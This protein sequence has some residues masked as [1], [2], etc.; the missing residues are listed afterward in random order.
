M[1]DDFMLII[2]FEF[3]ICLPGITLNYQL[4]LGSMYIDVQALLSS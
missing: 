1:S 3:K 4:P 2:C